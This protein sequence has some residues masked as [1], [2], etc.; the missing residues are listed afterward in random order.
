[1]NPWVK[2]F[3][4][5]L[6]TTLLVVFLSK[7]PVFA[8]PGRTASD[9]CHYCRTRCDYWGVTWNVRH[10][11]G[12][13]IPAS[14]PRVEQT[15]TPIIITP[16]PSPIPS[17]SPSLKPSPSPSPSPSLSPIPSPSPSLSPA[18][19]QSSEVKGETTQN[20]S[21]T[22]AARTIGSLGLMGALVWGAYKLIKKIVS[23]YGHS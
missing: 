22:S 16:I 23:Q 4:P 12:G 15:P 6:V 9:G 1:M 10:C 20:T 18:P 14:P 13:A 19:Q 17:P 3:L 21:S 2:K 7:T 11:H 5:I 8:H